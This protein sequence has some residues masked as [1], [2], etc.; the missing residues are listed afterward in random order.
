MHINVTDCLSHCTD[1]SALRR[2]VVSRPL[3]GQM[4]SIHK[5]PRTCSVL[6]R[7][8]PA[9]VN[10]EFI[11]LYF[12]TEKNGGGEVTHV[13]RSGNHVIVTFA[14]FEGNPN[15]FMLHSAYLLH[16]NDKLSISFYMHI[17]TAL[18]MC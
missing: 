10:S 12:E 18:I 1:Y 8:V 6:V 16:Y 4:I 2:L 5:V 13:T 9:A 11:S 15:I 7:G 14:D 3:K 17:C